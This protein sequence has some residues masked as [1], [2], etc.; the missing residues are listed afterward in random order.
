M[1]T[2]EQ[3]N[4]AASS[5]T[6]SSINPGWFLSGMLIG[7][8]LGMAGGWWLTAGNLGLDMQLS[9]GPRQ[10]FPIDE[11]PGYATY[12]MDENPFAPTEE[13][14][15]GVIGDP[16]EA[17][18]AWDSL[19]ETEVFTNMPEP[20][21]R[22][23]YAE[24]ISESDSLPII[25][26]DLGTDS[27]PVAQPNKETAAVLK[28]VLTDADDTERKVLQEDLQDLSPEQA[29]ELLNI[30]NKVPPLVNAEVATIEVVQPVNSILIPHDLSSDVAKSGDETLVKDVNQ[31]L[32]AMKQSQKAIISEIPKVEIVDLEAKVSQ[33]RT[34]H[35]RIRALETIRGLLTGCQQPENDAPVQAAQSPEETAVE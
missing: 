15:I 34:Q 12:N 2:D 1:A 19:G 31:L 18:L 10:N 33:F 14:A 35:A 32:T 29:L 17:E 6:T 25:I 27:N 4:I 13:P 26:S 30:R 8:S 21:P 7:L 11:Q 16:L 5:A 24:P 3:Q 28:N 23:E 22:P 20:M 9:D